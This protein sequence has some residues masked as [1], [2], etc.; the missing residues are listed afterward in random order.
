MRNVSIAACL[1]FAFI[2]SAAVAAETPPAC[3][4]KKAT[5]K[6]TAFPHNQGMS[7]LGG[8]YYLGDAI[9]VYG[10]AGVPN[11]RPKCNYYYPKD[12][13]TATLQMTKPWIRAGVTDWT[14]PNGPVVGAVVQMEGGTPVGVPV[15][16]YRE[17]NP[18]GAPVAKLCYYST[19]GGPGSL[20]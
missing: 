13:G 10:T 1:I 14:C 7:I 6:M 17:T 2:G 20:N 3:A 9:F 5:F 4:A 12:F 19:N 8:G 15:K 18:S 11:V 16:L